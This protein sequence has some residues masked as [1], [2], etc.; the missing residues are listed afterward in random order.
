MAEKGK[1]IFFDFGG[2]GRGLY[3][4]GISIHPEDC[5]GGSKEYEGK[6]D[7][8][9]VTDAD[10]AAQ[11]VVRPKRSVPCPKMFGSSVKRAKKKWLDTSDS[12][13]SLTTTFT[14]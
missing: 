4:V 3:C 1:V 6:D 14:N 9:F 5:R 10:F 8:T 11:G 12:T 7:G 13:N 2:G